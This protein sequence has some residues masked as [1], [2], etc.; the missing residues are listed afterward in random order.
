MHTPFEGGGWDLAVEV[1]RLVEGEFNWLW[2]APV[3][4]RRDARVQRH[5][6]DEIMRDGK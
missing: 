1:A 5:V 2:R 3:A 6:A 4:A